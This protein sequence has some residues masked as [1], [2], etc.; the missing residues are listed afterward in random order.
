MTS[1]QLIFLNLTFMTFFLIYEVGKNFTQIL[2]II[3][4]LVGWLVRDLKNSS[5]FYI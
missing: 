2:T 5:T 3:G 1:T 4:W